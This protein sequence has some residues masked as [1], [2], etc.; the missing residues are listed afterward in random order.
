MKLQNPLGVARRAHREVSSLA[1]ARLGLLEDDVRTLE[2]VDQELA[3]REEELERDFRLRLT[4]VEKILLEFERRGNAFF[5]E[6][7]RLRRLRELLNRERLRED[8]EKTVVA[9]LPREV[10][11]R[12][13]GDGGLDGGGRAA[14]V[15]GRDGPPGRASGRARRPHGRAR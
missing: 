5:E 1:S 12:R 4:Q 7:L 8:F 10:E 13:R 2:A 6:R 9:D 14:P 3:T 15:A 11:R